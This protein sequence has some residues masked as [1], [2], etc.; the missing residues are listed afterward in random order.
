[1]T[2][3][4]EFV[5]FWGD[6]MSLLQQYLSQ[7]GYTDR[8]IRQARETGCAVS[9]ANWVN[10]F[11]DEELLFSHRRD[12]YTNVP[13]LSDNELHAHGHY[14]LVINIRGDVEYIQNDRHI[15]PRPYTVMWC[16]PGGMHALRLSAC[17]YER[18][19]IY[20]SPAF[21][22]RNGKSSAPILR[23]AEHSDIF[24]FCAE[25]HRAHT[26]Q[27]LLDRI[28][29]TLQSDL[30]YKNMLAKALVVE[31]F[32]F[33]NT[34]GMRQFESQNLSDPMA[35]VKKYIDCSYADISGVDEVAAEFHY[36]RE[37]LS[38]KF[39]SRF[40]TSVSEYLSRRRIMESARLLAHMSITD[41]CYAV[42]FRS[43]SVYIAAFKKNMGCL[44]SE[45]KK[46]LL[47][48]L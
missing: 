20:F 27:S 41:A 38:R 34:D 21:F 12:R 22:P 30:P 3:H 14:E 46:Q 19:V 2:Y 18:Y 35:E 15:H 45:Y 13:R 47:K 8:M 16:R 40:N 9:P 44:P 37:H 33:F 11:L 5:I 6:L 43:Q 4:F 17:E 39:K 23:F 31:L 29:Q 10:W 48:E 24:A 26:L 32:A 36:S 42:G 7:R 25:G 1:M 28:E